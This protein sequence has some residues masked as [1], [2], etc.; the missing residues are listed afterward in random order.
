MPSVLALCSLSGASHRTLQG[1]HQKK[2]GFCICCIQIEWAATK[3]AWT[4]KRIL[5]L[6]FDIWAWHL[7]ELSGSHP[8]CLQGT[9]I[10]VKKKLT[11]ILNVSTPP[12]SNMPQGQP[13]ALTFL[14]PPALVHAVTPLL[15]CQSANC[16]FPKPHREAAS[17]GLSAATGAFWRWRWLNFALV[18]CSL[19]CALPNNNNTCR[20]GLAGLIYDSQQGKK[21]PYP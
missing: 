8:E 13:G 16:C 19:C 7:P 2:V 17:L 21:K 5:T 11:T 14:F 9:C 10:P 4:E 3:L 6:G 15:T 20:V 1:M 18:P 12:W